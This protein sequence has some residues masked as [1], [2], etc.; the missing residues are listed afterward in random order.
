MTRPVDARWSG[1][2]WVFELS[3]ATGFLGKPRQ[4]LCVLTPT[5]LILRG[6]RLGG[7][8]ERIPLERIVDARVRLHPIPTWVVETTRGV[9]EVPC[10]AHDPEEVAAVGRR[11]L[12][13]AREC[14]AVLRQQRSGAAGEGWDALQSILRGVDRD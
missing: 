3:D 6:R 1:E 4:T 14:A 11:V 9:I 13:V 8:R 5:E 2:R 12:E 7:L 10:G